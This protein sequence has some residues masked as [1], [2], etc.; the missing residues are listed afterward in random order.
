MYRYIITSY[1][2]YD[3]MWCNYVSLYNTH[4]TFSLI[5]SVSCNVDSRYLH[6]ISIYIGWHNHF[7][8]SQIRNILPI[9]DICSKAHG[10]YILEVRSCSCQQWKDVWLGCKIL[11]DILLWATVLA[12]IR[13]EP[14]IRVHYVN[15]MQINFQVRLLIDQP[16]IL[17]HW[18][19]GKQYRDW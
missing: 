13:R 3:V 9:D 10:R 4:I 14:I 19:A 8:Q 18:L 1:N 16:M 6:R 11:A 15:D 5:D 17:Q 7:R 2:K 12:K